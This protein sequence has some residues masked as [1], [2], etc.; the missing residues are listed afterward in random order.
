MTYDDD[1]LRGYS[2]LLAIGISLV[3]WVLIAGIALAL[4]RLILRALGG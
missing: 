3:L 1:P 4:A 2:C